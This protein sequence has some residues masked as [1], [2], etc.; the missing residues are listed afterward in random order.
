MKT[1]LLTTVISLIIVSFSFAQINQIKQEVKAATIDTVKL[2][3]T[4]RNLEKDKKVET[5]SINTVNCSIKHRANNFRKRCWEDAKF[6]TTLSYDFKTKTPDKVPYCTYNQFVTYRINN[7]NRLLYNVKINSQQTTYQSEA[8]IGISQIFNISNNDT[9]VA[10]K[11][12]SDVLEEQTSSKASADS[13]RTKTNLDIQLANN[14]QDLSEIKELQNTRKDSSSTKTDKIAVHTDKTKGI[15]NESKDFMSLNMRLLQQLHSSIIKVLRSYNH[16]E[17]AKR[18]NNELVA[19]SVKDIDFKT[20]SETI[21]SILKKYPSIKRPEI[22]LSDFNNYYVEFT[23]NLS[24]YNQLLN[25]RIND[26]QEKAKGKLKND[27]SSISDQIQKDQQTQGNLTSIFAEITRLKNSVDNFDFNSLFASLNNIIFE[28][29]KESNFFIVSDPVQANTDIVN[30]KID[31]SAL[32]RVNSASN[33]DQRN[34]SIA[35]PVVGGFKFDFSTGIFI[36]S[37]LHDR[38]YRTVTVSKDTSMIKMNRND[39]LVNISIGAMMHISQ[40]CNNNIK[41]GGS[42]GTGLSSDNLSKLNT[43]FGPCLIIGKQEQLI[44][45]A[46]LAI[47]Q[48]DYLKSKYTLDNPIAKSEIDETLTEK[49]TRLG[50]FISFTYNLTSNKKE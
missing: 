21:D 27:E 30:F 36:T 13:I 46:G 17:N 1:R 12:T 41:V 42:I 15:N 24:L 38:Q 6:P 3:T 25:N 35:V 16:L 18:I 26:N 7:I 49:A 29:K 28:L 4:K 19:F 9:E 47:S 11:K 33:L 44:I 45:T 31:I 2:S 43:F 50:C 5:D 39:N 48:V 37:G 8:P 40:R 23:K 32:S 22:I 10:N 14:K 20:S 34:F